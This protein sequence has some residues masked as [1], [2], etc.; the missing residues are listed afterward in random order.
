MHHADLPSMVY[1]TLR[2][3]YTFIEA[4]QEGF[5]LKK[6]FRQTQL[7]TLLSECRSDLNH[8]REFFKVQDG[9][10][11]LTNIDQMKAQMERMHEDVL[12]FI[13]TFS[14]KSISE[15]SS[16]RT[17]LSGTSSNSLSLLPATPKIFH[18]REIELNSVVNILSQESARV[19]ILGGGGMG[20]TSLSCAVLHHPDVVAKYESR[21]FVATHSATTQ[22]ELA[23][24]IGAYIGL[25]PGRDMTKPVVQY[26]ARER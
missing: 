20:K 22:L 21:F 7:N 10:T 14:N 18:G 8:A 15:G 26:F 16:L 11:T 17:T 24:L 1:R 13:T 2:K 5:K 4:Q 12:E 9:V 25:K 6:F 19:A 23:E 3:I